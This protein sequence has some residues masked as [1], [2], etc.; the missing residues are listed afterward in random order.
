MIIV[1]GGCVL[2]G[3]LNTFNLWVAFFFFSFC[4]LDRGVF[5]LADGPFSITGLL[6]TL[7][8]PT[9]S[10]NVFEF[11]TGLK[12]QERTIHSFLE[13]FDEERFHSHFALGYSVTLPTLIKYCFLL[14]LIHFF[15][16]YPTL[17]IHRTAGQ[18]TVGFQENSY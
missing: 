10:I 3:L 12:C 15:L 14:V 16:P 9:S 13:C 7:S 17:L 5:L 2:F 1:A 11:M 8:L 18:K 4:L 6:H